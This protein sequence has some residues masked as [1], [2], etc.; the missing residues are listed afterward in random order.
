MRKIILVLHT[1]LDGFVA[2]PNGEMDW[3]KLDDEMFDLVGK[4]T[5]EA[6]TALYGRV[7]YQM[8]DS[9]WPTAADQPNATKHDIEHSIWYNKVE[10]VV[11]SRTMDSTGAI[12]TTFIGNNI[13]A[14]IEKLKK[15]AGKNIMIFGSPTAVHSLMEDNL[16]DDYWLFINPIIL[17]QG[18]P[19][20]VKTKD[21]IELNLVTTK[22]FSNGVAALNYAVVR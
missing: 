19:L 21:K 4:F 14:E 5:D 17:G 20:F 11:L 9:Y 10:K 15:R 7:T 22:V 16:I 1:T 13:P 2:G 6:D 3:I 18:I 8:M 12:K